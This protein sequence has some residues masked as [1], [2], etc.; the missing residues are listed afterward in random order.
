METVH[1]ILR[2]LRSSPGKWLLFARRDY[3]IGYTYADWA[4]LV[5]DRRSTSGYFT[6][7]GVNLVNWQSKK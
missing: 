4:A 6:L 7:V 3:L 5:T 2:Y 1:R